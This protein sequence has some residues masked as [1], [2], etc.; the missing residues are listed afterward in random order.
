MITYFCATN[1]P[2]GNPRRGFAF[3]EDGRAVAFWP[4]SYASYMA[5]PDSLHY[6][7]RR[8]MASGLTVTAAQYGRLC[9]LPSPAYWPEF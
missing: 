4:E 5:V 2:K 7:A 3:L 9:S 8:A 1:C 6:A